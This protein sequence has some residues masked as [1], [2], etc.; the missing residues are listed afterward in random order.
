MDSWFEVAVAATIFA[1]GNWDPAADG[2]GDPRLVVTEE[3]RNQR[4]DG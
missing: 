2:P 3:E 4:V 1:V